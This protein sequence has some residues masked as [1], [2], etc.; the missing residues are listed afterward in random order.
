MHCEE[1]HKKNLQQTIINLYKTNNVQNYS[2]PS[3]SVNMT[4][5]TNLSG[6]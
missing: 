4:N 5:V 2:Q 1:G 6:K 3:P